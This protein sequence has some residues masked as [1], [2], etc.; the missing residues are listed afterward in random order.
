MRIV[1]VCGRMGSLDQDLEVSNHDHDTIM[2]D[3][4]LKIAAHS[5]LLEAKV[6]QVEF[7]TC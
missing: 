7:L 5:D 6:E 1:T 2:S 3:L 4:V